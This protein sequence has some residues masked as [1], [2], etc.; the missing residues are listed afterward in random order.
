MP[1]A[2][3][4]YICV[5]I[6][7]YK[8]LWVYMYKIYPIAFY[9]YTYDTITNECVLSEQKKTEILFTMRSTYI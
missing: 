5:H 7:I 2:M 8:S 9:T 6:H 1:E 4:M 3:S